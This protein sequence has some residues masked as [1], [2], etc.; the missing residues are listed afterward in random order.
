MRPLSVSVIGAPETTEERYIVE[1]APDRYWAGVI[2]QNG[3]EV[4]TTASPL[5]ATEMPLEAAERLARQIG[6]LPRYATARVR[7]LTVSYSL[8]DVR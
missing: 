8:T 7:R 2:S 1:V 6:G 3:F 5:T 4:R